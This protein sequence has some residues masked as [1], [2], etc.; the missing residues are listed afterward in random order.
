MDAEGGPLAV[1]VPV[2]NEPAVAGTLDALYRQDTRSGVRHYL[3]DNASTDGTRER[4]D[5]FLA[6][7]PGFPLT[8]LE[9][10][11]KGTGAASDTGFRRAIA[12]GC[13]LVARTDA[14]SVPR[15]DW[16]GRIRG[17]F[18]ARPDLALLGGRSVPL[19]DLH[20]RPGDALAIPAASLILRGALAAG[21]RDLSYFRLVAGHN[22]ATRAAGYEEA[23]GF[24]RSSIDELDEDIEYSLRIARTFGRRAVAIDRNLV[25]A[26]SM[27]RIRAYG[28]GRT[29][30]HHL[31]PGLRGKLARDTDIR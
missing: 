22:L 3:V 17:T 25:V 20:R 1:V 19:D 18:A 24:P 7:H 12:D 23:G 28:F 5:R 16:T 9:E 30:L 2:F 13:P 27:R 8:V 31:L 11:Q 14:D 6:S 26:T 29:A 10:D 4:V 15:R 21:H